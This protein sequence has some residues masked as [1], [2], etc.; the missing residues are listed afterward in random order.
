M[1]IKGKVSGELKA[2]LYHFTA[3]AAALDCLGEL[4]GPTAPTEAATQALNDDG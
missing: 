4:A 2:P 3:Y 1:I